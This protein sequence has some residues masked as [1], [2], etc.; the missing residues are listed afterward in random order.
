MAGDIDSA[1]HLLEEKDHFRLLEREATERHFSRLRAGER[2][3]LDT[4]SLHL[5]LIRDL[6]RIGSHIAATA[7]PL[8]EASGDLRA[9]RLA[10][11]APDTQEAVEP[12]QG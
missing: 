5:D 12:H 10:E 4:S 9:S 2:D 6:K 1:R 3:T 8:L 7:Y 11:E